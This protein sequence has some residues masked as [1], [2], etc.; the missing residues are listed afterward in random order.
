M[1]PHYN[2]VGLVDLFRDL[3]PFYHKI[4]KNE[5]LFPFI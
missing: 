5:E 1:N 2:P 3:K 4:N